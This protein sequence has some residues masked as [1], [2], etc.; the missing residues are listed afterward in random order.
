MSRVAPAT[1]RFDDRVGVCGSTAAGGAGFEFVQHDHERPHERPAVGLGVGEVEEGRP[2]CPVVLWTGR[3][4]GAP[5]RTASS[6]TLSLNQT[7]E[8]LAAS[9]D[10]ARVA[11]FEQV[12]C[13]DGRCCDAVGM[14]DGDVILDDAE[15]GVGDHGGRG[16]MVADHDVVVLVRAVR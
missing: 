10:S 3:A 6:A 9:L 13:H 16:V 5:A 1:P 14:R 11:G 15:H 12:E 7:R 8:Q 4:T 2:Q